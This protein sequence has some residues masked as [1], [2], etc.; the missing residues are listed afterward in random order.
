MADPAATT[1]VRGWIGPSVMVWLHRPQPTPYWLVSTRHPDE[2][3][4]AIQQARHGHRD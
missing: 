4:A 3:A 2:L 1:V